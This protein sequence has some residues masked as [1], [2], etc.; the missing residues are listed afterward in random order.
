M[1]AAKL[2]ARHSGFVEAIAQLQGALT[3][4]AAQPPSGARTRLELR[5]RLAL[6]GIYAEYRGFSSKECAEEYGAALALCRALGE[7]PEIFS[8]L[9]G[10]GAVEITRA[11]FGQ[12]RALAEECLTLA[13]RQQ[14]KAPFIMGHLLL[15][16]T[17]FLCGEFIAAREHLEKALALYDENAAAR[18]ARQVLY[19]QDQKSTGLSYLCLTLAAL[20]YPDLAAS[21]AWVP[22]IDPLAP[23]VDAWPVP[24]FLGASVVGGVALLVWVFRVRR[25]DV[26]PDEILVW[27]GLR[28][29]P[30]RYPRPLYGKIVRLENAVY[31]GRS[32]GVTL[33]NPSASPMLRDGEAPWVAAVL[34]HALRTTSPR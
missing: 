22:A 11:N 7:A 29:F 4:L 31:V 12:C 32:E 15:G 23:L 17:Q 1:R 6:G 19:V 10:V 33:V 9:S 24:W 18:V 25:V 13:A 20:G 27:R 21:L 5:V 14:A 26:A 28:P 8:V 30:R 3:L 34:R 2:S 16:G